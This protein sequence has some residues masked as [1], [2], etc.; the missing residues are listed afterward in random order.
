MA[1]GVGASTSRYS[2]RSAHLQVQ[3]CEKCEDWRHA[4]QTYV[5]ND[6]HAGLPAAFCNPHDDVRSPVSN[7]L[8][9]IE[10]PYKSL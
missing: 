6:L 9:R 3:H 7:S 8:I 2:E 10:L 4:L 5:I 1:P